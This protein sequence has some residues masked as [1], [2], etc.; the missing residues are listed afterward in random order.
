MS[1]LSSIQGTFSNVLE[2]LPTCNK[3]VAKVGVGTG[4]GIVAIAIT[5][6]AA[7][8]LAAKGTILAA[9]AGAVSP[10]GWVV[11]GVVGLTVAAIGLYIL[12]KK[13]P[14]EEAEKEAGFARLF[15]RLEKADGPDDEENQKAAQSGQP[16]T[17]EER[18]LLALCR[19]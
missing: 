5:A 9:I 6:L 17:Q 3:T 8:G 2:K 7:Q 18:E 12:F 4:T 16:L 15:D 19:V 1:V 13:P 14:A 11:I 10:V